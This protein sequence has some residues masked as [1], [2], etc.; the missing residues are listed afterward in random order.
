MDSFYLWQ[1]SPGLSILVLIVSA[2]I[3]MYFA[4]EPFQRVL[5]TLAQGL[6][7]GLHLIASW[8]GEAAERL[9]SSSSELL[10]EAGRDSQE[11]HVDQEFRRL[12]SSY[13]RDLVDYPKLHLK[14]DE[15]ITAIDST[16]RDAAEVP[17]AAPGWGEVV[18]AI[19]R[20]QGMNSQTVESMLDDIHES[21]IEAE[22]EALQEY[23]ASSAKRH[24][25]LASMAPRWKELKGVLERVGKSVDGPWSIDRVSTARPTMWR[26][27]SSICAAST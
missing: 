26:S 3:F 23:R 8:A 7:G 4:R 22:K 12:E 20:V 2:V 9:R 5:K 21:A 16:F 6:S 18:E 11:K 10:L 19:T 13:A 17:P 15:N 24:K 1:D 27:S 25:I 14:L